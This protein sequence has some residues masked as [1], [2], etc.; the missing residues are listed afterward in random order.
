MKISKTFGGNKINTYLCIAFEN[1]SL[2]K[3][4]FGEMVEWSITAVLKTAVLRGTGG[5]NPSLS[6]KRSCKYLQDL[7]SLVYSINLTRS[8]LH[9]KRFKYKC[10]TGNNST[11]HQRK[12]NITI[13]TPT[14][15]SSEVPINGNLAA[16]FVSKDL[17]E[18]LLTFSFQPYFCGV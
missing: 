3:K 9:T 1:E 11:T 16:L 10:V 13:Y 17:N 5:S 2:S 6:A 14:Q 12:Q 15:T 7:F 4:S 18:S 8:F